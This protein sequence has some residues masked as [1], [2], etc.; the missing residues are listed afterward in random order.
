MKKRSII[1]ALEVIF[2]LVT[3]CTP[4]GTTA[5]AKTP[6]ELPQ[7]VDLPAPV[8][9]PNMTYLHPNPVETQM[10]IYGGTLVQAGFFPTPTSFDGHRQV[11]YGPTAVLPVFNQLVQFD[12]NFKD[13]VPETIIGDLAE[14]WETSPDG[15]AVTFK[16]HR[17][18]KWHDG[19]P[20]TADDVVYSLDKL[21]DFNRSAISATFPAY[22]SAEKL[23]DN[24]VKVNLKYPSASFLISLAAGEAVI[25]AR[26][27]AG[28]DDQSAAFMVGTGPFILTEYLPEVHLKYKRNPEYFKNDKYGNQLPYLDGIIYYY[29]ANA[30]NN[31]MLISRRIDIKNATTGVA[32]ADSLKQLRDGAPELLFQRRERDS[33]VPI[34]LN[35]SHSPLN[36]IRVRRALALVVNQPDLAIG[37]SGDASLGLPDSGI[38]TPSFGL[39]RDEVRKLMGWDKPIA[40]RISEARRLLS[41][42]GYPD[43][44]NLDILAPGGSMTSGGVALVYS[45]TLRQNLGIK[46]N[47]T[48]QIANAELQQRVQAGNYD[49]YVV[50]IRIGQDPIS[51]ATYFSSNGYGNFSNY[52]NSGLDSRLG[53]LDR[54]I[55]PVKRRD[56]VWDIERTLLTDLPAL[57]SGCFI[58]NFMPYYPWVKNIRWNDMA[59]S[60]ANRLEDVWIDESQR[61]K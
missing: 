50:G 59:Y 26:H 13:T 57:P 35:L 52:S 43:G 7:A 25:E 6:A 20:F 36:D 31:D 14:S 21:T 51:L 9:L 58:A 49:V 38:L 61:T 1:I 16:L 46:S 44:F 23:D 33:S 39:S 27:L 15:L 10:P 37:Y 11:S 2:L 56:A 48:T 28:T 40:E 34:F 53:D 30:L 17:G 22:Q 3:A 42:A 32:T 47:V 29:A 12:I 60:A 19:V 4:P 8:K 5:P 45:E 55:D 54:V 41:E 18:L 24:T